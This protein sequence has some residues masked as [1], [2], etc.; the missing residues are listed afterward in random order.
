M[1][2]KELFD[3]LA[4][5]YQTKRI[6]VTKRKLL[7]ERFYEYLYM[8]VSVKNASHCSEMASPV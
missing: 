8:K 6:I 5:F 7:A 4:K 3:I 2:I 1:D